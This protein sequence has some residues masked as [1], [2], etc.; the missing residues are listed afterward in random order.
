MSSQAFQLL[1]LELRQH[2]YDQGWPKLHDIQAAAIKNIISSP[3]NF[4][5]VSRTA[6][7]KTEAALLP[8]I[9]LINNWYGSVKIVYVSPLI[10]LINDQ[11]QRLD[12]LCQAG[13]IRVTRWHGE[14]KL[15]LKRK[16]LKSPQGILLITPESIEAM[17]VNRPEYLNQLFSAVKFVIVDEIHAFLSSNRGRHLQSLLHRLTHFSQAKPR[18]IG[19]SATVSPASYPAIKSFYNRNHQAT[20]III[21]KS[22]NQIKERVDYLPAEP[23]SSNLPPDLLDDLYTLTQKSRALIFPNSRARVEEIAVGLKRRAQRAG[24]HLN[25]YAHHSSVAKDLRASAERFAKNS[26]GRNFAISCT[27]TLELGIDIGAV[28]TIVQIDAT[29]SVASLVQR[30]GRSGRL[31][32]RSQLRL[33][34]TQPWPLMQAVASIE[35]YRDRFIEPIESSTST[36][37]VYLHQLLSVIRQHS[38]LSQ[39]KLLNLLAANPVSTNIDKTEQLA[40]INHLLETGILEQIDADLIIGLK[41]ERICGYNFYN[42][43]KTPIEMRVVH[44]GNLIGNL[45]RGTNLQIGQNI[46]LAAYIWQITAINRQSNKIEVVPAKDGQAPIFIGDGSPIHSQICQKILDILRSDQQYDYLS[47]RAQAEIESLRTDLGHLRAKPNS[48]FRPLLSTTIKGA[49]RQ[50]WY[51]FAGTKIANTLHFWLQHHHQLNKLSLQQPQSA[52]IIEQ[53]GDQQAILSK[54]VAT[55]TKQGLNN[56]DFYQL[57][58]RVLTAKVIQMPEAKFAELL[59]PHLRIKQ[60]IAD[61]FDISGTDDFLKKVVI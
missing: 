10:A 37:N 4:V 24:G 7:G 43:F 56:A 30:L 31:T 21:D 29:F 1:K 11:F 61:N 40:I 55:A 54:A 47:Q 36:Y 42:L 39:A 53:T 35:L 3:A 19:L 23:Q 18:F 28:D 45:T 2:I 8:A 20:K 49:N 5:L 9:S 34:G 16:L 51:T 48:W 12:K 59:P 25:Y 33:Y 50:R 14:A 44:N 58:R 13:D 52:C 41:G 17:M 22:Q 27:S 6:S 38:G 60:L 15:S 46:Y 26:P 32:G 57:A